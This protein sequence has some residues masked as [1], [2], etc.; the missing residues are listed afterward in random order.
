MAILIPPKN[1]PLPK[2]IG[3]LIAEKN[4]NAIF[5]DDAQWWVEAPTI[6]VWESWLKD[7]LPS[8]WGESLH[9]L[10]YKMTQGK[11]ARMYKQMYIVSDYQPVDVTI[12]LPFD[13]AIT[14]DEV[15][16]KFGLSQTE[17]LLGLLTQVTSSLLHASQD[18]HEQ[19]NK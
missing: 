17:V 5:H 7:V 16:G 3:Q 8:P 14:L 11:Y 4:Q 15:S 12:P 19:E 10:T 6:M 18:I 2:F 1:F 13:I 9:A